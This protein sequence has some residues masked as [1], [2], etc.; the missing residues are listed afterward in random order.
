MRE[1][2]RTSEAQI[3]RDCSCPRART[4]WPRFRQPPKEKSSPF[5]FDKYLKN[6]E[7][8]ADAAFVAALILF[9]KTRA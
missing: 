3:T 1:P 4:G 7:Y 9:W 5:R 2:Y 6:R 8:Q